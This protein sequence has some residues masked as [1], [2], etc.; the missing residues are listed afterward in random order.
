MDTQINNTWQQRIQI[1]QVVEKS[2]FLHQGKWLDRDQ[3]QQKF[4]HLME[5]L[6]ATGIID[7]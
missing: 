3:V 1:C 7:S 4:P 6:N 2:Q 5:E